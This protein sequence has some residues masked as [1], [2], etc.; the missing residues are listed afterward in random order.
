MSYCAWD[1][2]GVIHAGDTLDLQ[3]DYNSAEPVPGAMGIMVMA[4]Y[5]TDDLTASTPPPPD[6]T[7]EIM[8]PSAGGTPPKDGAS[9]HH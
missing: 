1:T 7:G 5:Q 2:L 6:A 3:A 8:P 4:L 9:H